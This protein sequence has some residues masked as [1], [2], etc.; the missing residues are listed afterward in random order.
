MATNYPL[1]RLVSQT[2]PPHVWYCRT[3]GHSS[4]GVA[5]GNALQSTDFVV[6]AG[7]PAGRYRL[8]VVANGIA[9]PDRA[10]TV[11]AQAPPSAQ[12][13]TLPASA[14]A[15]SQTAGASPATPSPKMS[16]FQ[17]LTTA[18]KNIVHD[19]RAFFICFLL[20]SVLW[21]V[22]A[23][24]A[25]AFG[26]DSSGWLVRLA[27]FCRVLAVAG[28][29]SA[30]AM[31]TGGAVGFLFGIPRSLSSSAADVARALPDAAGI[32]KVQPNTN[33]EQI[34]DWLTKIIVG[35]GLTQL[36]KTQQLLDYAA[37]ALAPGFAPIAGG[38]LFGMAILFAFGFAG[39]FWA[40]FE[41]RTSLM[42][43][44]GDEGST[45]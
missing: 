25:A 27:M 15:L 42:R 39:F 43:V 30:A 41:C 1:V 31:I 6:P 28:S 45:S 9:S 12:I 32:N 4:M 29:L 21:I 5:T 34:S 33:L 3:S 13:E 23:A 44:F 38:T 11:A 7:V 35:V 37:A 40:Y 22:V 2:Q 8:N 36:A 16:L 24:A 14:V 18:N 17:R 19:V 26:V 20:G 10:V